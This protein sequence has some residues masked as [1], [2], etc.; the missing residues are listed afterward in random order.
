MT[1]NYYVHN[2]DSFALKFPTWFPIDGVRWYGISYLFSFIF[3]IFALNFYTRR[4]KSPLST[5][6][7]LSFLNHT[8]CGVL[9]GGRVG[10]VVLYSLESFLKNPLEIFAIWRGGMASH[11]GFIGVIVAMAMF[12][13]K[14]N[15]PIFSLADICSTIAPFGFFIGRIANFINGELYGKITTVKWAVIFPKSAHNAVDISLIPPRHPS[16]LYEA[17]LEGLILFLYAQMRFWTKRNDKPGCLSG[18]FLI[19]YAAFRIFAECFREPDA[20][21]I[22]SMTRGQFYSIFFLILGATL[23]T[24]P[25]KRN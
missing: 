18:E 7:N 1:T 19:L 10:Y 4:K 15:V 11:G 3:T 24:F 23:V 6:Q 14:N 25:I 5:D 2:I 17:F 12:C 8:I 22:L 20:P 9:I 13:K 16:Q 21:L